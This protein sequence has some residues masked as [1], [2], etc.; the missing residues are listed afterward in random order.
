MSNQEPVSLRRM[1]MLCR[2]ASE[3][4]ERSKY[5]LFKVLQSEIFYLSVFR[6]AI[7]EA[8]N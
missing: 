6:H 7:W 3:L 8:R 2:I 1:A 5:E 4:G